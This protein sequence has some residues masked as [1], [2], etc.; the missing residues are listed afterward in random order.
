MSAL[1]LDDRLAPSEQVVI[2]E[3]A[4]E[5]VILDLKSGS[6]FGLNGVGTRAWGLMATGGSLR[7]VHDAL[8]DE[9]DAPPSAIQVELLRFA[10]ELCEHGLCRLAEP[11]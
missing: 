4:G 8:S 7:E 5:S 11:R 2:R 9:F 10:A 3:L 1:S 6:Y